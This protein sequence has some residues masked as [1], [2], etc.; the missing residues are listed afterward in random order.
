MALANL[1]SDA[2]TLPTNNISHE[3]VRGQRRGRHDRAVGD[4]AVLHG[5]TTTTMAVSQQCSTGYQTCCCTY[6]D[7]QVRVGVVIA[8]DDPPRIADG[9]WHAAIE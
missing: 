3:W 8:I 6:G 7:P 5:E 9:S 4:G 2:L 1:G